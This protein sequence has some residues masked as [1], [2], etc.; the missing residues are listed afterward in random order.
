MNYKLALAGLALSVSSIANAALIGLSSADVDTGK[1]YSI[2][3]ITGQATEL[4]SLGLT[5]LVGATFLDGKFY[6]TDVCSNPCF[7]MGEI[8]INNGDYTALNNQDGSFNWHGLASNE[9]L[10][11]MYAI[12]LDDNNILIK[13]VFDLLTCC[14]LG[15]N[16]KQQNVFQTIHK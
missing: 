15:F 9:S 5:S 2:D 6:G 12:D 4:A 1:V 7:S 8:D 11:L 16:F 13:G 10:G 3:P 14:F